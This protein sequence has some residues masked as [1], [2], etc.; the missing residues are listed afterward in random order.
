V[1]RTH[2]SITS[3]PIS[4]IEINQILFADES[5]FLNDGS[6]ESFENLVNGG[7]PIYRVVL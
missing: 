6:K 7:L 2:K 1:I 3:Q 5:I 4:A